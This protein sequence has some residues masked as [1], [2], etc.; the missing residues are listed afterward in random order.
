MGKIFKINLYAE[1]KR[2]EKNKLKLETVEETILKYKDWLK[3][4]NRE[5]KIESYEKFLRVR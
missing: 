5:D 2:K 1:S 4:N 3:K